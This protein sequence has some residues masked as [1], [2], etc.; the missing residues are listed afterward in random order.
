M[1]TLRV[2]ACRTPVL[3]ETSIREPENPG[4]RFPEFLMEW[5][6]LIRAKSERAAL[7]AWQPPRQLRYM[8][9]VANSNL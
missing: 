6:R 5:R 3:P 9:R 2:I 7:L 1:Y 8:L 4:A